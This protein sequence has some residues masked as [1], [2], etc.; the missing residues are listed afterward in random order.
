MP[1]ARQKDEH[2][3]LGDVVA[4]EAHAVLLVPHGQ[5]QPAELADSIQRVKH[6]AADQQDAVDE[7]QDV[8]GGSVRMSQPCSVLRSVMPLMPPVSPV[9]RRSGPRES[10][11]MAWV[12]IAK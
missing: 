9:G 2:L 10:A 1:A 5:Q 3:E 6:H 12:M 7:V 11:A 4:G 8:L